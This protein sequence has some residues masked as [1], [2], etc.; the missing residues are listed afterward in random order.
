MSAKGQK[1]KSCYARTVLV[2]QTSGN[3]MEKEYHRPVR[4]REK[5]STTILGTACKKSAEHLLTGRGRPH[6]LRIQ[7]NMRGPLLNGRSARQSS[8]R[9]EFSVWVRTP[10]GRDRVLTQPERYTPGITGGGHHPFKIF[11]ETPLARLMRRANLDVTP[12]PTGVP[13]LSHAHERADPFR[14]LRLKHREGSCGE[15]QGLTAI[16]GIRVEV[17]SAGFHDDR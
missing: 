11:P 12:I 6:R 3:R 16:F 15:A 4:R 5:R 17:P 1:Q 9:L 8:I 13:V 14:P 10:I 2:P 7:H